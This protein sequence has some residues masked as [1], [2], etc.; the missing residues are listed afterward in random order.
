[1]PPLI[2]DK[3][4]AQRLER[5]DARGTAD[6]AD[7]LAQLD[8]QSAARSLEIAGGYAVVTGARFPINAAVGLGMNGPVT[9]L[10]LDTVEAFFD[11]SGMPTVI[12]LCPMADTSLLELLARRYY[13]FKQFFS[14]HARALGAADTDP[15][16]PDGLHIRILEPDEIGRWVLA[17]TG[18][19]DTPENSWAVLAR[20]AFQ[21]PGAHCF[22]AERDGHLAGGGGLAL[23]EGVAILFSAFTHPNFRR[24]GIQQALLAARLAT[25]ARAGVDLA[26]VTTTPG[27][28]SQRNVLRA[29]FQVMY[30]RVVLQRE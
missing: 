10:D 11:A 14:I 15:E 3:Q 27:A 2:L 12:N 30:T 17:V 23:R 13:R 28:D 26:F 7:R 25:A 20:A 9:A 21:R 16:L 1:M 19:P 22:L 8:P 6:Y 4:L 18:G 29:G 24:Q 5:A